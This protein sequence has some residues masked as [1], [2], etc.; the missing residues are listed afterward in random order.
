M[1][2]LKHHDAVPLEMRSGTVYTLH[3]MVM[4]PWLSPEVRVQ[5]HLLHVTKFTASRD[6][7]SSSHNL[8]PQVHQKARA[9]IKDNVDPGPIEETVAP[10]WRR[11]VGAPEVWGTAPNS[12]PKEFGRSECQQA[13]TRHG[14]GQSRVDIRQTENCSYKQVHRPW[15]TGALLMEFLVRKRI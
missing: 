11:D 1:C 8:F 5:K 6:V 7:A 3:V 4:P 12:A 14:E 15:F 10:P 9:T 2:W 13:A